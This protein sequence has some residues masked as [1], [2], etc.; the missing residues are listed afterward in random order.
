MSEMNELEA[1]LRRWAELEPERCKFLDGA[2]PISGFYVSGAYGD[3]SVYQKGRHAHPAYIEAAVRE[4]IE[5]RGWT[6]IIES[7]TTAPRY[8]A[9]LDEMGNASLEWENADTP[10]AALLSAYIKALESLTP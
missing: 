7:S 2:G 4:C 1:L 3:V 9:A 10:A 8:G 6:W 5:S